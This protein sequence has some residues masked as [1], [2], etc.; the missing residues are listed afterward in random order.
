[1]ITILNGKLTIPESE[2]FI[3][4][5]G[6]NLARTIE[7]LLCGQKEADRIYRLYLTFDDGT[8]NHF[9]LPSAVTKDGVL[10]TWDVQKGH[11]FKSGNVRAQI[12]A[13]SGTGV[14]YH[15]RPDT[16]IVG[17]SAEFSDFFG[18]ENSEFLEYEEMLNNLKA[19]VQE[20]C[21]LAPYIGENGNWYIYDA[22]KGEYV[23]S[24][25][26]SY[27]EGQTITVD[28]TYS[29]KSEN[30]QSGKAVA[31]A[32]AGV[33]LSEGSVELKHFS[34]ELLIP[35]DKLEGIYWENENMLS[36]MSYEFL[37]E[38]MQAE[39]DKTGGWSK[40][41]FRLGFISSF[42]QYSLVG[43]DEYIGITDTVSDKL[44]LIN[45]AKGELYTYKKG[46][47]TIVKTTS[48]SELSEGCVELKH[49][50]EE[51]L[52][53]EDKL[54]GI[55]WENENMLS[56]MSYE[57]LNG[58]MQAECDK[59]GGWSKTVFRL[60]FISAFPQY[61]LVGSDEYIGITDTV[62]DN[63]LLINL[64]SG[65]LFTYKKGSSSIEISASSGAQVDLDYNP[66]SENAQ[67]GIAVAQALENAE[68]KIAEGSVELKHFSEELLIPEDKLEGIYWENKNML[69][70]MS[71]ELLDGLLQT[72]CDET[73]GW[74]KTIFR[75]K[76]ISAFPYYDILGSDEYIGITDTVSDNLLLINLVSGE[77]FTYVKGSSCILR[78]G[79]EAEADKTFVNAGTFASYS[80][81]D[82]YDFEAGKLYFFELNGYFPNNI[83]NI[84]NP[85]NQIK[86]Y[87]TGM[88]N[89][90]LKQLWFRIPYSDSTTYYLHNIGNES[91][92]THVSHTDEY[93]SDNGNQP[94]SGKGVAQAL[95]PIYSMLSGVE[96]LLAG[97]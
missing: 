4:F 12:K 69:S 80:E 97:I 17:N 86:G 15:T 88:Y 18:T 13:F 34:D 73:G 8:V 37:D 1:M 53:P 7:F 29:P 76:F 26:S 19:Q 78:A 52:I 38:L 42:P 84:S 89:S 46:S 40:T 58:L 75:L 28:Q 68:A 44:L 87:F 66:D 10:L 96:Q 21:T 90:S 14:V 93:N 65:E 70:V 23:D 24:G 59:T 95:S 92:A 56:V 36:V 27:A 50:S 39:C 51:L 74:S 81:L 49:F 77:L 6:D 32:V 71:F 55:Y 91:I 9:V 45:I 64:V 79:A 25:R 62:S 16:F 31:Q 57:L 83:V 43:S 94:I 85:S 30:P 54:E 22:T 20:I 61:S 35:E 47:G 82:S 60:R 67:S 48:S 72:E 3:G 41:V 11:I 63:L 5:A 2:R 33:K